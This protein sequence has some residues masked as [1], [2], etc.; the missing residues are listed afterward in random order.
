MFR[1]CALALLVVS[2]ISQV[3]SAAE[4]EAVFSLNTKSFKGS[5]SIDRGLRVYPK[6]CAFLITDGKRKLVDDELRRLRRR[7]GAHVAPPVADDPPPLLARLTDLDQSVTFAPST[8]PGKASG[9]TFHY[10]YIDSAIDRYVVFVPWTAL[11]EFVK[12]ELRS[13]FGGER[14]LDE[15][16]KTD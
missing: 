5:V 12:P 15:V 6:L 4:H 1:R 10:A 2:V 16:D 13:L 11:I 14:R 7:K 9:L 3:T 8:V